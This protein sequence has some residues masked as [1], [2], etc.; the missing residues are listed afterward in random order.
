MKKFKFFI[1]L[2]PNGNDRYN[3]VTDPYLIQ[4]SEEIINYSS[5]IES[6]RVDFDMEENQESLMVDFKDIDGCNYSCT[7]YQDLT[8]E[9]IQIVK[10]DF[11][12]DEYIPIIVFPYNIRLDHTEFLDYLRSMPR[13][14]QNSL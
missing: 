2:M 11:G 7:I 9:L 8:Y 12:E 6:V 5:W 14:V 10:D 1:G 13:T 3:G 4:L